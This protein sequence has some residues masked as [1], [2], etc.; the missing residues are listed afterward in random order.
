MSV[1]IARRFEPSHSSF[2]Q[3]LIINIFKPRVVAL[4][5]ISVALKVKNRKWKV[6]LITVLDRYALQIVKAGCL[7]ELLAT[8]ATCTIKRNN[9]DAP[10]SWKKG[11]SQAVSRGDS[12]MPRRNSPVWSFVPWEPAL[13]LLTFQLSLVGKKTQRQS[14]L[15]HRFQRA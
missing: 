14:V 3:N 5:Y 15:I 9:W 6:D 10:H 7:R 4:S 2:W 1:W 8:N 11:T 13:E 12:L